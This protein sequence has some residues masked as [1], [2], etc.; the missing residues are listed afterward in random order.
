MSAVSIKEASTAFKVPFSTLQGCLSGRSSNKNGHFKQQI[1]L[2]LQQD[3]L[4][5]WCVSF[6]Q[7]AEPLSHLDLCTK[8]FQITGRKPS[9]CWVQQFLEKNPSLVAKWA[10]PLDSK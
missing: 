2:P 9:I 4:V 5:D 3:V 1:L 8:V 7:H 6:T 10:S